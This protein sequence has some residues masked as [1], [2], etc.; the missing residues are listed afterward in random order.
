MSNVKG[1]RLVF[2]GNH[3]VLIFCL[4]ERIFILS[5]YIIEK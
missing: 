5:D 1:I 3:L 2:K 4:N